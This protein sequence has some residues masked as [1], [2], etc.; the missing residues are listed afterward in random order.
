M[1]KKIII[2]IF[3]IL[4]FVAGFYFRADIL[5]LY[6]NFTNGVD[7]FKKTDIGTTLSEVG[8]EILTPPP[9]LINRKEAS[10][11]LNAE[12]IISETNLQRAQN[13]GLLALKENSKLTAAALAKANDMFAKQYF[14]HV[15]PTGIDPGKLVQNAGYSYIIAGENLI[16]GNFS[17]EKEAVQDWMN[18]PG[19]RANILN[20]RFTEIGVAVVKGVYEGETVWIGVQEFG[21]PLSNCPEPSE[22]LKNE[23]DSDKTYLDDLALQINQIRSEIDNTSAR[24]KQYNQLISSYNQLVN[25]YNNLSANIKNIISQYNTQVNN[26]NN[27]VV[28][29]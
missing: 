18:S 3:I 8:R 17:S 7:S 15:S 13:G 20:T 11:T 10:V 28:G 4:A 26:F 2:F 19:H 5:K 21:L 22:A 14:E 29:K 1:L 6:N 24:S 25:D 23:I 27:C 12:K 9:L 16:L